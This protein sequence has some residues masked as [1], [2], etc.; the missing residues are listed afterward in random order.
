MSGLEW[1]GE[2]LQ[3]AALG[4]CFLWI[5]RVE[6]RHVALR[7]NTQTALDN[8]NARVSIYNAPGVAA[9]PKS[10]VLGALAA[11]VARRIGKMLER[12]DVSD[13]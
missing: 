10:F 11:V 6:R 9:S 1:L 2:F 13:E 8:L 4:V 3:W 12:E 7:D 5:A